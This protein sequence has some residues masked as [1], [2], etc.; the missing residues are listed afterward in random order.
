MTTDPP[1][2]SL[3]RNG[4]LVR[5]WEETTPWHGVRWV[6]HVKDLTERPGAAVR[7]ALA[8]MDD[9][10]GS[11][12]QV[13]TLAEILAEARLWLEGRRRYWFEQAGELKVQAE[14]ET[15]KREKKAEARA[16][17]LRTKYVDY[18]GK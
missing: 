5:L 9:V 17:R 12:Y 4:L 8:L 2:W 16:K 1:I 11:L 10:T 15:R 7:T 18:Y 6:L 13:S 14:A 3:E